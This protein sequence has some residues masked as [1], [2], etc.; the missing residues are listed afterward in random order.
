METHE[1]TKQ[2][3]LKTATNLFAYKGFN[4]VSVREICKKAGV[5]LCMISYYFGGKQE[6][7]HAIIDDLIKKQTQYA[8]TFFDFSLDPRTL[9]KQE[10]V[11]LLGQLLE[12]FIDFFYS[13]ISEDLILLLLEEQQNPKFNAKTPAFDYLSKV[14][15]AVFNME[16]NSKEAV[17]Q[18][19]FIISQINC[20]RIFPA[21]S[22]RL[23][24]QDSFNQEDITI[25]KSNIKRYIN[26]M[27]KDKNIGGSLK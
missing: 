19:L 10:Q 17:Y 16:E 21:F 24:G 15:A 23:L 18:N 5:S 7:Y 9:E 4:S 12:R 8:H 2:K 22:I 13:N 20:L 6:L 3:I 11:D 27:L 25:V 14:V 1:N 26:L